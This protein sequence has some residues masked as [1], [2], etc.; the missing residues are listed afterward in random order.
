MKTMAAGNLLKTGAVTVEEELRYVWSQPVSTIV[1][2]MAELEHLKANIKTAQNFIPM[3][4]EEQD[5]VLAKTR[6]F[7]LTGEYETFK[8]KTG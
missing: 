1:S 6:K 3:S 4:Q 5:K 8:A 2:G 7:A